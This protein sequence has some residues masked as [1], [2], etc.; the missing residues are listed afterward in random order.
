MKR[1]A[2][3]FVLAVLLLMPI[4]AL[5]GNSQ[6]SCEGGKCSNVKI[7]KLT[8]SPKGEKFPMKVGFTSHISG[9]VKRVE[10]VV[11]D[12]K[13]GKKVASCSSFCSKCTKRGI[14]T[15]SCI[16]KE[17]GTYNVKMTAYGPGKCCVSLTKKD[18][19]SGGKTVE[20]PE[21]IVPSF[22]SVASK[23]KVTFKD[24]STGIKPTKW[25]WTFGDGSKSTKQNP[26]HVY[27]KAGN[28]NVCLTV[29]DNGNCESVCKRIVVK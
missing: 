29:C 4:T 11:I 16:I 14:C 1:I 9:P 6:T 18:I 24:T 2:T 7:T 27:K 15:C 8:I 13:T 23:K 19:L 20:E 22:K 26:T 28:Y 21:K 5:A 12:S 3:L 10:Y 25:T 17:P